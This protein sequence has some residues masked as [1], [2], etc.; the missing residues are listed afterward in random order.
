MD[1]E[2]LHW[3]HP[4]LRVYGRKLFPEPDGGRD[5]CRKT[6][7]DKVTNSFETTFWETEKGL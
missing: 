3:S 6:V 4:R 5:F 7:Y 1:G 2:Q